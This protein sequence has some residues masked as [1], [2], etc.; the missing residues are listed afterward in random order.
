MTAARDV[1]ATLFDRLSATLGVDEE[2]HYAIEESSWESRVR[3]LEKGLYAPAWISLTVCGRETDALTLM[4]LYPRKPERE[5]WLVSAPHP[6]L[7]VRGGPRATGIWM[8][9]RGDQQSQEVSLTFDRT[10][11]LLA[12]PWTHNFMPTVLSVIT[13]ATEMSKDVERT[14]SWGCP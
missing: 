14:V 11:F 7:T 2:E 3:K 5:A 13:L 1:P 8:H 6:V 10:P 4:R 9:G 12:D